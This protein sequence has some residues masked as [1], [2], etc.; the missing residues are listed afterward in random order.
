M[1]AID[2]LHAY[3]EKYDRFLHTGNPSTDI[4]NAILLHSEGDGSDLPSFLVVENAEEVAAAK[5]ATQTTNVTGTAVPPS[6]AMV[7]PSIPGM[8]STPPPIATVPD[9]KLFIAVGGQQYGPYGIDLCR[10]MVK[11]GQLTPMSMVWMEGLPAW[12]EASLVPALQS[13]FAPP[14]S[15]AM[16]PLPPVGNPT[17]PSLG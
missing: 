1:R 7:P 3:K 4:G 9:I 15:P 16:P 12:I 13:L 2:W 10:Q 6:A 5:A 11:G 17:P 14:A 8:A